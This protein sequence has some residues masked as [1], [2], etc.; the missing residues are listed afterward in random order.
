VAYVSGESF[1]ANNG[2]KN[3]M[4]LNYTTMPEALIVEGIKILSNVLKKELNYA[5]EQV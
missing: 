1:F 3:T 5:C 4:R 2:P